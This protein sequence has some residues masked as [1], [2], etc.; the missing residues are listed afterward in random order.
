MS[1]KAVNPQNQAGNVIGN[2]QCVA[3]VRAVSSAPATGGWTEGVKVRGSGIAENTCIATFQDGKYGNH[4][5]GRSH[6]AVLIAEVTAGLNVWD[7]WT[8]QPVHK[9]VIRFKGGVGPANNDG[10]A[11]SVIE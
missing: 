9:R 7:Q 3:F 1:Y 5:D 6:A 4:T 10:D 2:G 11:Y 8:G